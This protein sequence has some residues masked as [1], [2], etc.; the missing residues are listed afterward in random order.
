MIKPAGC[1]RGSKPVVVATAADFFSDGEKGM[2]LLGMLLKACD[3]S[4]PGRPTDVS[5]KWNTLIYEEFYAEGDID[6][7]AGRKVNPLH[8]RAN[9]DIAKSTIGFIGT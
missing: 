2:L 5:D 3:I 6:A 4:N 7:A 1:E 8:D 9:N